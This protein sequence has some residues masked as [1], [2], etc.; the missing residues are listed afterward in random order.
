MNSK[1][2]GMSLS[3]RRRSVIVEGDPRRALIAT[4][5]NPE[6]FPEEVD[7]DDDDDDDDD[8]EEEEEEEDEEETEDEEASLVFRRNGGTRRAPTASF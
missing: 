4:Q 2:K 7:D 6:P 1:G 3:D 8:E 5:S